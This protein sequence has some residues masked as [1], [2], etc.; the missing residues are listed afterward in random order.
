MSVIFLLFCCQ[1]LP[2]LDRKH[3]EIRVCV[4]CTAVCSSRQVVAASSRYSVLN[5]YGLIELDI[6]A[7]FQRAQAEPFPSC[8]LDTIS[9]VMCLSPDF[10]SGIF[11]S[12]QRLSNKCLLISRKKSS[13]SVLTKPSLLIVSLASC[14]RKL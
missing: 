13:P 14:F 9:L 3:H 4:L 11:A 2:S 12:C 5:N 1:S 7:S 8:G 6:P 10:F